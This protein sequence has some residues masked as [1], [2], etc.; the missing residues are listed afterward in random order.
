MALIHGGNLDQIKEKYPDF[1]GKWLDLSTGVSPFAYDVKGFDLT[2][3]TKLPEGT[4][5]L[6]KAAK[7]YY[8]VD[9]L[10]MTPGS[11]WTIKQLPSILGPQLNS[12]QSVLIPSR[13]F[14]EHRLAWE[15][16]GF[17]IEWYEHIPTKEQI[18]I[19][20]VCVMINP[21]NPTGELLSEAEI[22]LLL[23][24]TEVSNC[25]LVMDEAFIDTKSNSSIISYI[26][27]PWPGHLILLR[28]FGKF[29][30]LPG[31]RLGSVIANKR[32]LIEA[33]ERLG[34]WAINSLAQNIA[35]Q[36]YQDKQWQA[37]AR[38][39][40]CDMSSAL[41]NDLLELDWQ[42]NVSDLFVTC[43][44]RDAKVVWEFLLTQGVYTRLLD[45]ESGIRIGLPKNKQDLTRLKNS[46]KE[47][48][49][50]KL[51]VAS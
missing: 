39:K 22:K 27:E 2:C 32:F 17:K 35:T 19:A 50:Q 34:P 6:K 37:R 42:I 10:V 24:T 33:E 16:A 31:L 12:N 30:G 28:S 51:K 21:N 26:D 23:K 11:I 40:I 45:D 20:A 7:H 46:I 43:F 48:N 9:D 36:A 5:E 18:E 25:F 8:G 47:F 29:F 13:G 38:K 41:S 14:A 44:V 3:M 49:E 1:N 4:G 15:M